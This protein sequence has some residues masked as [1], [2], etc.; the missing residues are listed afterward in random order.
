M[1]SIGNEQ[2]M[3][4]KPAVVLIVFRRANLTERVLEAIAE[5]AP[6]RLFV[7][8]D[9]P[10]DSKPEDEKEVEETRKLFENISWDCELTK[11]YSDK[12]L[13][14][15]SRVLTGLDEVFSRVDSAII[16]EDDCLPSQDFFSFS[17]QLL[18]KYSFDE[19]VGLISGNN[20][21]PKKGA[22][23]SYYFSRHANIWGWATWA[24]TW[25]AFRDFKNL[26]ELTAEERSTILSF[27]VGKGQKRVFA[28]LLRL[29]PK[30]DS[31]AIQ[32]AAFAYTRGLST[33]VP[34][35]NLVR[36][37]GFGADSTHTKFESWSDEIPL[38]KMTFPLV[39]PSNSQP[40]IREMLR[41]SRIKRFRWIA[42]PFLNPGEASKRIFRYLRLILSQS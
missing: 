21:A 35:A 28:K 39:H 19:S 20:F 12:N 15:R 10:R 42:Y 34:G 1:T 24:R 22:E 16:L 32:F 23:G 9:G 27:V 4:S 29:S 11:I 17:S 31:W 33:I 40:N 36:N 26:D 7:I 8:A 38:G 3:E 6:S 5:F 25:R 30:L 14:L 13:G 18:G 41:E 37:V 2:K